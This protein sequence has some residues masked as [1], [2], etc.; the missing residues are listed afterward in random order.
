MV[1]FICL[2][3]LIC[4]VE[5]AW[6]AV[7]FGVRIHC[8]N[9]QIGINI[10]PCYLVLLLH[11]H[12][13]AF[14]VVSHSALLCAQE[15][16]EFLENRNRAR[17]PNAAESKAFRGSTCTWWMGPAGWAGFVFCYL[18]QSATACSY[19]QN[20]FFEEFYRAMNKINLVA[21]TTS[22]FIDLREH[23]EK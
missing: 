4:I 8:F 6:V 20:V 10:I 21:K 22:C 3:S 7:H 23:I 17:S 5:F 1:I 18:A 12:T 16:R 9:L 14:L 11:C 13:G 2:V 15:S 19:F